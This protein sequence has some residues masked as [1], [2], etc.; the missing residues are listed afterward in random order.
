MPNTAPYDSNFTVPER[1][2]V[3]RLS[4]R[5]AAA[6][7]TSSSA[8]SESKATPTASPTWDAWSQSSGDPMD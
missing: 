2:H 1:L 4:S 7:G 6:T 5:R 8:R 3:D